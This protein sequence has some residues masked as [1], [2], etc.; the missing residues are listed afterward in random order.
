MSLKIDES[1]LVGEFEHYERVLID[2]DLASHLL[3]S[4]LL[5]REMGCITGKSFFT[6]TSQIFLMF[7]I[8]LVMLL[9][10]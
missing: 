2:L 4:I 6:K 9:L 10:L 5:N 7:A 8:V 1:T 3:V